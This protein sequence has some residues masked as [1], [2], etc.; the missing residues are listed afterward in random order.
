LKRIKDRILVI[1]L[2]RV[3]LP[4][5]LFLENKGFKLI[6]LDSNK[7]LIKKLKKKKMPFLETGCNKLLSRSKAKFY[8]SYNELNAS[9]FKYIFITVGTP[10]REGIEVNLSSL[11][12]VINDLSKIIRKQHMIIL[13]STIGPETTNYVKNKLE[14]L[15]K[16]KVGKDIY[17]AFCPERMAENKAIKELKEMPQIIGVE[18]DRSFKLVEKIFKKFK[19]KIFRTTYLSAELVKLF[20]NNYRYLEFAIANQ[21]AIIANNYNQNIYE[22]IKMCN[23]KY[24]RGRIYSPGLTGGTCLRKDF[25]ML[26]EKNSGTDLFLSAWKVNEYIPFHLA[27]TI[28]EKFNLKG[29]KIGILGYTFK[30]DSDDVRESLV[31][32]LIRQIEKKVPQTIKISEPFI[33]NKYI[34]NY[35]NKDMVYISKNSDIIFLAINHTKFKK[36]IIF[37]NLRKGTKI[38][39]IWNHFKTGRFIFEK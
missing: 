28:C 27:E 3:G 9:D 25:G 11:N 5:L 23:E 7:Q 34:D 8:S 33:K 26:N 20:N 2:G 24:P 29:K 35:E 21:F 18:D 14:K 19:I 15:T 13:R 32:K 38:I 4:F 17:L 31:P 39:D 30:K 16:Y 36:Q 10:L 37:K 1:G 6:G 22:I 12:L